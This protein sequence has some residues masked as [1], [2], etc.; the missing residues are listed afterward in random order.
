MPPEMG[1]SE[2]FA[3]RKALE[4]RVEE[5]SKAL[6]EQKS[7]AKAND[8]ALLKLTEIVSMP[9]RKSAK[10]VSDMPFIGRAA[11][12]EPSTERKPLTKAQVDVKLKSKIRDGSL[13]KSDKDLVAKYAVGALDISKIEH[14]LVDA[15]K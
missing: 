12:D 14:L 15:S 10:G 8:E 7:L 5:L 1:K 6:N 11:G 9:V 2:A 13:T 3:G 4:A